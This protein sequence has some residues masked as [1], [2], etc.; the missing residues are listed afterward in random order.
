MYIITVKPGRYSHPNSH[1]A[2]ANYHPMPFLNET[3]PTPSNDFSS[4]IQA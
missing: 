4:Y 2:S 1:A 3:T